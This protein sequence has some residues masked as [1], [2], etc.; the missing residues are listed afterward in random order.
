MADDGTFAT[1]AEIKRKAGANASSVSTA[2]AYTDQFILEAESYINA[3]TLYNWTDAYATLFDYTKMI[4][5]EAG[6][7]LAAIYCLNYDMSGF[8][9]R[10]EA[11]MML[12]VLWARVEECLKLLEKE[13]NRDF[14][15]SA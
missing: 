14:V 6:S 12:N 5:K 11:L 10:Q 1:N 9:S 2:V 7:S 15:G 4:L 3:R 13:A 8:T